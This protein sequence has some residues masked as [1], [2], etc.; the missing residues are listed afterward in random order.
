MILSTEHSAAQE[1]NTLEI[2][3][4]GKIQTKPVGSSILMTCKPRVADTKLISNIRWIDPHNNSI[5]SLK[6]PSYSK[7]SMYTEIHQDSSL[8]LFFNSLKEEQ[9]GKYICSAHYA[10][11]NLLSVEV[12]IDTI[13]AITWDDAPE[14]QF[15]ILGEDFAIK[16]KV[17]ARPSPTVD[18]LY[19]GEVIRTNDHYVI[20][21]HA[22]KIKNVKESDDGVYT[23]RASVTE[24]GELQER[25]IRVEVHTRPKIKEFENPLREVTEGDN[26]NIVCNGTGKPPPKFAWIKTMTK[27]NL[28]TADRFGVNKDTGVLTITNVRREDSS[29]YQCTASNAA[30]ITTMNIQLNVLI[31][32]K[33]MEFLNQTVGQGGNVTLSCKAFGRPPPSIIFRKHTTSNP[34]TIGAQM[35][36]DRIILNNRFDDQNDE[37]IGELKIDQALRSNDGMYECIAN[38]KGGI[39][40]KNGHL[41][42][43]FPPSFAS[44]NNRTIWSWDARPVNL[45]CIVESIPNAT[46]RWTYYGDQKVE[47]D[48]QIKI[49]GNG[50]ISH[51]LIIPVSKRYYTQY[52]CI[53][54]NR[55]GEAFHLLELRDAPKPTEIPQVRMVETTATTITFNIVPP[56]APDDLPIRTIIVQYRKQDTG[57]NTARNRTWAVGSH[58]IYVVE[59]LEPQ[60]NYEF[61]FAA[62]NEAGRGNWGMN[63]RFSTTM[64]SVPGLAHFLPTPEGAYILSHYHDKY[65]AKW[66]VAPDNGMSIDYYEVKWCKVKKYTG[67]Q[68]ELVENTC[69]SKFETKRDTW[70]SGLYPDTYYKIELRAHNELGFGAPANIT[71]KTTRGNV[72]NASVLQH[73]GSVISSAAIIGIAIA[74]FIVIMLIIDTIL[75]CTNKSGII[76]YMCERSRRKPVDEEDAKLGRDEKEPLK[77]E[78]K[79]T[80]IIDSGLRRESS[81]TFD[82][83]RS[84]S[85]TG[86]VGK[87]SAV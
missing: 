9:A 71:I 86:F 32:P 2:L 21:T 22:L 81:V 84:I 60:T 18:W 1:R 85:K 45:T 75:Y 8:S 64:R 73:H 48:P 57:W 34:Y 51:L 36:D 78:K 20:E 69:H 66:S 16:C 31:K 25:T 46:I 3:P 49:I 53:A 14:N 13:V 61:R 5:E 72:S 40:F 33:I 43:E 19:N 15:P 79:I 4:S 82:G 27:E 68:W 24:T 74:A 63:K 7:P 11:I 83:K 37:T 67:D 62:S 39:A 54:N 30:G 42:V 76:Y 17:R 65:N 77:E 52:K 35:N 87:D 56:V 47:N 58:G 23:C 70:I 38:N 29:E 55:Y 28:A 12:I 50:P 6:S 80:P 10:N 44:M 41:T 59:N 26:V